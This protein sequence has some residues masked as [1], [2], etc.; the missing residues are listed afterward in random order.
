MFKEQCQRDHE[1]ECGQNPDNFIPCK[2]LNS[3]CYK[4]GERLFFYCTNCDLNICEKCEGHE[5]HIVKIMNQMKIDEKEIKL[6]NYKIEFAKNY[7][8]YIEKQ[9]NEFKKNWI[10]DIK[11]SM[12]NFEEKTK[13]F[14]ESNRNQISLLQSV[15]NT[16]K[17]KG[18]ICIENYKN[19]KKFGN[20]QEFK[21]ILPCE[22]NA[23]RQYI[24]EFTNNRLIK[25][26]LRKNKGKKK[27]KAYKNL[28]QIKN[29]SE[30][31]IIEIY[32]KLND[33]YEINKIEKEEN[34]KK[35]IEYSLNVFLSKNE[36]FNDNNY[37]YNIF[38]ENNIW[39][40]INYLPN[41]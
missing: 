38:I 2:N 37:W 31:I 25:E 23:K 24:E 27:P 13:E 41:L 32:N 12:E 34:I 10:D 16:Y 35:A 36:I 14:L 21:F 15:L 28:E 39:D 30:E 19:I 22:I 6:Y 5:N 20:I 4:H 9:I 1:N 29:A 11:R 33:L 7:L 8:N 26:K 40:I 17:I 18:N 3:L